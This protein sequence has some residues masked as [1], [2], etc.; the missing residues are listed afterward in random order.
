M[1]AKLYVF[2]FNDQMYIIRLAVISTNQAEDRIICP[3]NFTISTAWMALSDLVRSHNIRVGE[4]TAQIL[5]KVFELGYYTNNP[6]TDIEVLEIVKGGFIYHDI[7]KAFIPEDI[8]MKPFNLAEEEI[9]IM[10]KHTLLGGE[11]LKRQAKLK[12]LGDND[13]LLWEYAAEIA[14]F[15][16]EKWSGGG[17][18]SGGRYTEISLASRACS[19]ADVYD[20]LTNDR[21][22]R[23]AIAH[24][25]AMA[26]IERGR[27]VQFDPY[28]VLAFQVCAEKFR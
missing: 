22:Y 9:Q 17:Y 11:L 25:A 14:T 24:S 27:G 19:I 5:K 7:G 26:E 10:K 18:P 1:N 6:E 3:D 23:K 4:I 28:L 21:P 15:H 13:R 8:V 20:A 2:C 12:S 16:H